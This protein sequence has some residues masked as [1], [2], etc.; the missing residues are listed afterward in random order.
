MLVCEKRWEDGHFAIGAI[1]LQELSC[2]AGAES[3]P[4]GSLVF[5][6]ELEAAA[7]PSR[8]VQPSAFCIE[9]MA[10]LFLWPPS[11]AFSRGA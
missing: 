6:P 3:E 7:Y 10:S 2:G 11:I 8:D 1:G 5:S 4:S 9:V